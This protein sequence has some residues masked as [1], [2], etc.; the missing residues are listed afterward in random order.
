M[1]VIEE[2]KEFTPESFQ[3]VQHLLAELSDE[4]PVLTEARFRTIVNS[5]N[6]RLF[7]VRAS[8]GRIAGMA[9]LGIYAI[10]TGVKAWLEDLVTAAAHRSKGYGKRLV[11]HAIALAQ[12]AGADTL[13]L[14]SRPSREAAN[15]LYRNLGFER[16]ETNV[17]RM[18][19]NH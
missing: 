10:P 17:Y 13:M 1:T 16:R 8:D 7:I 6:A 12:S 19:M 14:T 18:K 5:E 2:I 15:R 11:Q 3:A 9:T 4:A